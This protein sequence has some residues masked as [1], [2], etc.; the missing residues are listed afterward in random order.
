MLSFDLDLFSCLILVNGTSSMQSLSFQEILGISGS[1]YDS[2]T[3][4]TFETEFWKCNLSGLVYVLR[5][6]SK[7]E[8]LTINV[9]R[10]HDNKVNAVVCHF[11]TKI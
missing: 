9:M 5:Y 3:D 10:N 11:D 4:L 1:P 8:V 7:L 2:V 6:F